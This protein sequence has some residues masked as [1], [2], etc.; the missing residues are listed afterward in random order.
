MGMTLISTVFVPR[1]AE[2]LWTS[3]YLQRIVRLFAEKANYVIRGD[4][5]KEVFGL[6]H[7]V[8]IKKKI[9][10]EELQSSSSPY[11]S[12]FTPGI[13]QLLEETM[14]QIAQGQDIP[15][16]LKIN[17]FSTALEDRRR[18]QEWSYYLWPEDN[19]ACI[20]VNMQLFSGDPGEPY[21]VNLYHEMYNICHPLVA[22]IKFGQTE[23]HE[24]FEEIQAYQIKYLQ[25]HYNFWGPEIVATMG[26]E[27]ILSA[28]SCSVK[29]LSDGGILLIPFKKN[30]VAQHLGLKSWHW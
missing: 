9:T 13:S 21:L 26:R 24:T 23:P 25:P 16:E 1:R 5:H 4:E 18:Y 30:E 3:S 6:W 29:E 14:A 19:Q 10:V 15:Q 2:E 20:V 17:A 8:L 11:A 12:L 27:R 28:P 22:Y 7:D